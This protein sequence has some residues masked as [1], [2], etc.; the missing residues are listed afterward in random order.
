MHPHPGCGVLQA[1]P[2]T[3]DPLDFHY[4]L[5]ADPDSAVDA[6]GG[7]ARARPDGKVSRAS[8]S[9]CD[10]VAGRGRDALA[11]ELEVEAVRRRQA[12]ALPGAAS[13][14]A[15]KRS[16]ENQVA[17]SGVASSTMSEATSSAVAGAREMPAPSCPVATHTFS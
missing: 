7:A 16:G 2:H 12:T 10:R 9:C 1:A 14:A 4:A 5:K 6:S 15:P 8:Q 13:S 17:I 11:V 3:A